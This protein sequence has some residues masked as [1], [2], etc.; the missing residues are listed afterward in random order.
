LNPAPENFAD[1]RA[2]FLLAFKPP[3]Y[4]LDV[5]TK[6]QDR[7]QGEDEPFMIYCH[8]IIYLCSGVDRSMSE[9]A[10]VPHL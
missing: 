1:L 9:A 2:Q 10:K 4:D 3:N 8:D 6:L 7:I 5:E